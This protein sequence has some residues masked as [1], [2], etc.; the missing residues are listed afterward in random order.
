MNT[1]L[2]VMFSLMVT[3]FAVFGLNIDRSL[4]LHKRFNALLGLSLP[5]ELDLLQVI[6]E[7]NEEN[8]EAQ[9]ERKPYSKR[10]SK[11]A[12]FW[13][14]CDPHY[15]KFQ[16]SKTQTTTKAPNPLILSDY[17]KI[18]RNN[19]FMNALKG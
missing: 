3:N 8:R 5:A 7:Y 17:P 11:V 4:A 9:D 10:W 18:I 15:R 2:F 1:K 13:K 6:K 16:D 19:I 12:C 14:I